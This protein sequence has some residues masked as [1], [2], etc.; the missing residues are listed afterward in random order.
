MEGQIHTDNTMAK[1]R[2]ART[3]N[4][5]QSTAKKKLNIEQTEPR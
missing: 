5:I 4:G 2:S 1:I 3:N